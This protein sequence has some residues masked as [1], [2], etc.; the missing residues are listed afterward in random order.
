MKVSGYRVGPTEVESAGMHHPAVANIAVIE[1]KLGVG[2]N[3]IKAIILL[4]DG[5]TQSES[6]KLEISNFIRTVSAPFKKP[7]EIEFFNLDQWQKYVT[8]S[9]K[10]KRAELRKREAINT[11]TEAHEKSI[12]SI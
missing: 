2:N 1:K 5:Y 11:K 12:L 7:R 9:G 10:I 8:T 6:L 3:I 4:K